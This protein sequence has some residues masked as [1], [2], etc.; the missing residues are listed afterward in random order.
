LQ[1]PQARE[2][3]TEGRKLRVSTRRRGN[4]KKEGGKYEPCEEKGGKK[5]GGERGVEAYSD[6]LPP[7]GSSTFRLDNGGPDRTGVEGSR[8]LSGGK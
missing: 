6:R 7:G 8:L 5:C 2:G 3:E 4:R 1:T